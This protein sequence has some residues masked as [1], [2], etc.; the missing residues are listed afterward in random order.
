MIVAEYLRELA[1]ASAGGYEGDSIGI[2][3][4]VVHF[5]KIS[6]GRPRLGAPNTVQLYCSAPFRLQNCLP[7]LYLPYIYIRTHRKVPAVGSFRL[8]YHT[9]R[10]NFPSIRILKSYGLWDVAPCGFIINR[11]FGGTCHIHLQSR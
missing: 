11:R 1:T 5:A 10:H 6:R 4:M 8:S 2:M 3:L 9:M 7:S